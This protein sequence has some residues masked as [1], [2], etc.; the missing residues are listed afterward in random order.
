LFPG[1]VADRLKN[2]SENSRQKA[3]FFQQRCSHYF[4]RVVADNMK[5]SSENTL[6]APLIP[7]CLG[8][9]TWQGGPLKETSA[10]RLFI[11]SLASSLTIVTPL[12]APLILACLGC[13]T[14]QGR[15]QGNYCP[16]AFHYFSRVVADDMNDS[17]GS[18]SHSCLLRLHYL[19]SK[20]VRKPVPPGF[21]LFL[22]RRRWWH[23]WLLRRCTAVAVRLLPVAHY[24]QPDRLLYILGCW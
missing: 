11:I 15:Q 2:S 23:E 8:C 19:E 5:N 4:S 14:W 1:V 6:G 17:S 3:G 22:S 7:A 13:T 20:Q 18:A 12:G 10:P 16:Q 9:T 24:Q 21:S